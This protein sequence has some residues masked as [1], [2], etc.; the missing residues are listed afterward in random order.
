M[1][2]GR[3][4]HMPSSGCLSC[5]LAV[6]IDTDDKLFMLGEARALHY[7]SVKPLKTQKLNSLWPLLPYA[8]DSIRMY[9]YCICMQGLEYK[10]TIST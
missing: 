3:F 5:H 10:M 6:I 9:V 4:S 1:D 2:D 7:Y 8:C